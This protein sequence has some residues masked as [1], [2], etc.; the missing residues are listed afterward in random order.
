MA[1][2]GSAGALLGVRHEHRPERAHLLEQSREVVPADA[3]AGRDD[4]ARWVAPRDLEVLVVDRRPDLD[5]VAAERPLG[6]GANGDDNRLRR[7]VLLEARSHREDP[8]ESLAGAPLELVQPGAL[9]RLPS[10]IG[11]DARHGAHLGGDRVRLHE[12]EAHRPCQTLADEDG[13]A[14]RARRVRSERRAVREPGDQLLPPL[15]P[16]RLA[17]PRGGRD[18]CAR[19][20]RQARPRGKRQPVRTARV[21]DDELVTLDETER[22]AGGA[23]SC[24]N[25][26]DHSR[27]HLLDCEGGRER[28]GE[29]LQALDAEPR[30]LL[31]F[32]SERGALLSSP[33]AIA[34]TRDEQAG[35]E[36]R[37]PAKEII[38]R[39]E[40]GRKSWLGERPSRDRPPH[41]DGGNGSLDTYGPH[42]DG[43]SAEKGGVDGIAARRDEEEPT[44]QG[45]DEPYARARED[46]GVPS[47]RVRAEVSMGPGI[48]EAYAPRQLAPQLGV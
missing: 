13:N 29:C 23:E 27:S 17:L 21:D 24:R 2:R 16:G 19:L 20:Q 31:A 44:H 46:A 5:D 30:A 33:E 14:K 12:G 3:C 37:R 7:R 35:C 42:G 34:H 48:P 8:V 41:D 36:R 28:G 47:P 15:S 6:L 4:V 25:A 39:L 32:R 45:A 11:C 9:E 18:R 1:V 40:P 43:D 26:L 38:G 22:P 10:E